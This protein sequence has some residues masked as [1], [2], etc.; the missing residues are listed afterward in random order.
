MYYYDPRLRYSV[1]GD[2]TC[3][4]GRSMQTPHHTTYTR[5]PDETL[6][7]MAQSGDE[8]AA[9]ELI[10]RHRTA[11]VKLAVSILRN[12]R[13]AEDEVQNAVTRAYLHLGKFQ[14]DSKFSTWLSR[15]V[16][17]QCL[18]RLRAARRSRT[19]YINDMSAQPCRPFD[20]AAC[21][22]TPEQALATAEVSSVLRNEIQR[23]PPLLRNVVVLHEVE[24]LPMQ[25]V[26]EKL[27]I[28]VAAA[29]SRLVRARLELRHRLERHMD[30]TGPAS[31]VA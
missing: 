29:K 21:D 14:R 15:I 3:S 13:N 16:V 9:A 5:Q 31:L 18:M 4:D 23:I 26:A 11:C 12:A 22:A 27:G 20:P 28:S 25:I 6:V 7:I 17:N 1:P 8:G 24:Q 30:R 19:I 10:R 2:M